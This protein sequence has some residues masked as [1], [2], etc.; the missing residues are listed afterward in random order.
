MKR[1]IITILAC[2]MGVVLHHFVP[3]LAIGMVMGLLV[4]NICFHDYR[5]IEKDV[6]VIDDEGVKSYFVHGC[7]KCGKVTFQRYSQL[8][9]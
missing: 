2:V 1:T 6:T 7:R 5:M 8:G 4:G 9:E 3:S